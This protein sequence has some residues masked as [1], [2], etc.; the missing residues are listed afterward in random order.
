MKVISFKTFFNY[1]TKNGLYTVITLLGFSV[2]LTFVLLL[3]VYLEQELS[4]DQFHVN[5]GRIYRLCNDKGAS[6]APPIGE[7]VKK[8]LPEV[9]TF[10]RIYRNT[11][12]AVFPGKQPARFEYMLADSSFFTMFSFKLKEG[13]PKLVLSSKNLAVLSA[14]FARKVFGDEDPVGKAFTIL[15]PTPQSFIISGIAEDL[16]Q[17]T[18]FLKCDAVLNFN[19]LAELWEIKDLLKSYYFSSY[20]LY[21]LAKKGTDLPSRAPQIL[22]R[23]KK[24]YWIFSSNSSVAAKTLKFEPLTEVYLSKKWGPDIRQNNRTTLFILGT[25]SLLILIVAIINYIN[26]TVAQSALKSRET[27]IRKLMGSSMMDLLLQHVVMSIGLVLIAAL[28]AIGFAFSA[29]PFFNTNMNCDLHLDRQFHWSSICIMIL[30]IIVIGFV[31]GVVPAVMVNKVNLIGVVKGNVSLRTKSTYSKILIAFQYTVAIVLLICTWTIA[32]QSKFMLRYNP[33]FDREN[34]FWMDNTIKANQKP[35]FRKMLKSIPGVTEVSYCRGTPLDGGN[36]PTFNYKG[37]QLNFHEFVVDS[38]YFDLMGI[39]VKKTQ[40]P[41]SKDGVWLNKVAIQ[42]L[43]LGEN[44]VSFTYN[45]RDLPVLGIIDNFNF[46]P[47]HTKIAPL[48]VKQL[49]ENDEPWVIMVR[50]SGPDAN[51]TASKIRDAQALFTRGIPMDSGLAGDAIN[52]WYSYEVK[53][54]VLIGA[55]TVLS[56]II[57]SMG[58]FAMSLYYIQQK[59]KEIGIRKVSGAKV[60]EV[61]MM[62]NKDLVKWVFVAF[63]IAV[64]IAWY[65]T[66]KWLENFAYKTEQNWWIFALSGLLTLVIAVIT[67]S[68]QSWRAATRNPVETLRYE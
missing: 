36:N 43:G 49:K 27:A 40:V 8:Q 64:P 63:V 53:S 38:L 44:P 11:G 34:L 16:P 33:G 66:K 45:G 7:F 32:R 61:M 3:S 65:A 37:K 10:T 62:L 67:I 5:K 35:A 58:I 52:Q 23:F 24:E 30:A 6:F 41:Y 21:F 42:L 54:S 51:A 25:I 17:N 31:S 9:E 59:I 56:I 19:A 68:W 15:S 28:L 4:V 2:S 26:L 46:R 50:L 14:S 1:L 18:H 48:I 47:L 39:K 55:F 22:D 12:N 13:D 29:E 60:I 20:G 57:S